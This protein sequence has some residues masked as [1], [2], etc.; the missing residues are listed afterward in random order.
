M[1]AFILCAGKG[2]RLKPFTD[3]LAKPAIPFLNIPMLFYPVWALK[4]LGIKNFLVN[5][6]HLPKTI[7]DTI[8]QCPD[9]NLNFETY[10]EST[11][12]GSGGPL[13]KAKI[14][15]KT[16]DH[17]ILANGD[18]VFFLHH[19]NVLQDFVKFHKENKATATIFLTQHT[20]RTQNHGSVWVDAKNFITGFGKTKPSN[21]NESDP[22]HYVGLIIMNRDCLDWFEEKESNIFY[23]IFMQ[24]LKTQKIMAYIS[25]DV[26]WFETGNINDYFSAFLSVYSLLKKSSQNSAQAFIQKNYAAMLKDFFPNLRLAADAQLTLPKDTQQLLQQNRSILK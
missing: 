7:E 3:S 23:D 1:K 14:S 5:T 12:L 25:S 2:E 26:T 13:A 4:K 10:F 9:R 11:L 18:S 16:E 17:F 20:E 21:M 6:H 24:K 15:L 8:Q 19:E 22:M